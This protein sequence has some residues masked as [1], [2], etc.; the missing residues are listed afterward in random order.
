MTARVVAAAIVAAAFA[1]GA[2]GGTVVSPSPSPSVAVPSTAPAVISDPPSAGAP[3]SAG[4]VVVDPALLDVLPAEVDGLQL[5]ADAETAAE[6]AALDLPAEVHSL[7]VGLYVDPAGDLAVVNVVGIEPGTAT[8]EWFRHWRDTYDASACEVV[9]GVE[10][11][12]AEADIG[13]HQTFIG[14]CT[15]GA[16]TYHVRLAD[17]DRIVSINAV[18][19]DRLGERIIAAMP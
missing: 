12:H 6:L 4:D 17:P 8:D 19:D 9:G 16:H 10:P 5:Q 15:Q 11:G 7:A 13:D 18:G 1:V 2:C 14:T 3:S